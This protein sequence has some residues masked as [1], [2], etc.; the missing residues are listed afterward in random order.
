MYGGAAAAS[1]PSQL[2]LA[3]GSDFLAQHPG[4]RAQAGGAYGNYSGYGAPVGD[5]GLLPQELRD[6]ARISPLDK[7]ISEITGMSDNGPAA[8]TMSGGGRRG[9]KS[10]KSRKAGKSRKG[11]K[12]RKGSRK[13]RKASRR[14]RQ[15]GGAFGNY[16]GSGSPL[17]AQNMLLS[18]QEAT[19]AGTADFSNPLLKD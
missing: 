14:S 13:S 7:S 12:A 15:R 10:K 6:T 4:Q 11:K 1:V 19:K 3:Q 17:S 5:Q 8:P 9:R 16:S 18:S 2:S